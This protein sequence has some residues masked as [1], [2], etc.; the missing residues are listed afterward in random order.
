MDNSMEKGKESSGNPEQSKA[1]E[2]LG[3]T[4]RGT[5][6]KGPDGRLIPKDE[7]DKAM[8][9]Y[10]RAEFYKKNP[11]AAEHEAM[12]A[13]LGE[14]EANPDRLEKFEGEHIRGPRDRGA[15]YA[16]LHNGEENGMYAGSINNA[17]RKE[18]ARMMH[19][20]EDMQTFASEDKYKDYIERER[21]KIGTV[22]K[23][24]DDFNHKIASHI[25]RLKEKRADG[26]YPFQQKPQGQQEFQPPAIWQFQPPAVIDPDPDPN[27]TVPDPDPDPNKTDP[28]PD[29][30][31]PVPVPD[32]NPNKPDPDPDPNPN[33]TDPVPDPDP[34]PS[35][36]EFKEQLVA[37]NADVSHD[38]KDLAKA[39]AEHA[40]NEERKGK[41]FFGRIKMNFLERYYKMKYEKELLNGEGTITVDGKEV[42]F[43]E[44]LRDRSSGAIGRIVRSVAE[45][46]MS[47]VHDK[48][49]ES[50]D[51]EADKETTEAVRKA[52]AEY[53]NARGK[54]ADEKLFKAKLREQL[55]LI[56][57]ESNDPDYVNN[58]FEVAENAIRF[59]DLAR[60]TVS[61]ENVL[62]QI[63]VYN[64]KVLDGSRN[65]VRRSF[66][67]RSI[68]KY[69]KSK[70]GN[71]IKPEFLAVASGVVSI[72]AN[73]GS[74]SAASII[75]PGGGIAATAALRGARTY[76]RVTRDRERLLR[77][78]EAGMEYQGEDAIESASTRAE[79]RRAKYEAKI[80]GTAYK[81]EKATKLTKD[82]DDAIA[83][84]DKEKILSAL[85]SA[86][87]R[88]EYSDS[89][90]RGLIAFSSEK[91][92]GNERLAL[93]TAIVKARRMLSDEADQKR[94]SA[95]E[96]TIQYSIESDI[97]EKD[98]SFNRIRAAMTAKQVAKSVA[99]GATTF[100]VSQEVIATLSPMKI[101]L[102]EKLGVLKTGNSDQAKETILASI[103]NRNTVIR[104]IPGDHQ[105]EIDQ[106]DNAGWKKVEVSK[107][108]TTTRPT[109]VDGDP[110]TSSHR[111]NIEVNEWANNRTPNIFEG[112]EQGIPDN[113]TGSIITNMTGDSV[114]ESGRVFNFEQ[115]VQDGKLKGVVSIDGVRYDIQGVVNNSGQVVFGSNGFF[116][117]TSGDLIQ[118]FDAAGNKLYQFFEVGAADGIDPV[119]GL[120]RFVPMATNVGTGYNGGNFA[121]I[122]QEAGT[123]IVDIPGVYDF[124]PPEVDVT[125]AGVPFLVDAEDGL[126][127]PRQN[128]NT[129]APNGRGAGE[130]TNVARRARAALVKLFNTIAANGRRAGESTNAARRAA[131][132]RLFNTIADN[133]ESFG[134]DAT[135]PYLN[136]TEGNLSDEQCE[137]LWN[138]LNDI[139]RRNLS[140][141][142]EI[143]SNQGINNARSL[144]NW[145]A[146]Q[147]T[148][149][150]TATAAA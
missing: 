132:V 31:K 129:E 57:K 80:G 105:A 89:E 82:I 65:E 146:R 97:D 133:K 40:F 148:A 69:E 71:V 53:A 3:N 140:R 20:A 145:L 63:E 86:K 143:F 32:P 42:A 29:P 90:R 120:E 38:R 76:N 49:G 21:E 34:T 95:I 33:K 118:G 60:G 41:G 68:E 112:N 27:K 37:V 58:Y 88:T 128:G 5:F 48:F 45:K 19:D 87:I 109:L 36:E 125:Y 73:I 61:F 115:L 56:R 10:E 47:F 85:A 46:E 17:K 72:L 104:G 83:S 50:R 77:D 43:D 9:A 1:W 98:R 93:D 64:A 70:L 144:R 52:I 11:G 55:R 106:Y 111:A 149:V 121:G 78:L 12:L 35:L 39:A 28:D 66:I 6:V 16:T 107:P 94:L 114:T 22:Y 79:R 99:I 150:T 122:F 138:N 137:N 134:G 44:V 136:E 59:K 102:L 2:S 142:F 108:S 24:Q 123:E 103:F 81:I 15:E 135:M 139:Q 51:K 30:N 54:G 74:S 126:G 4:P 23:N 18:M 8:E 141:L 127:T 67:D 7:F 84:G 96:K 116:T 14:M 92:R 101:G 75:V 117:T 110:A 130:S 100:V 119:T 124:Y 91:D 62:E 113:N 26:A 13:R 147:T 131:L 25:R